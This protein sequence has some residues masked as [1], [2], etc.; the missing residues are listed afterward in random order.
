MTSKTF[1]L[2][3][4][5]SRG[6]DFPLVRELRQEVLSWIEKERHPSWEPHLRPN[7]HGYPEGQFYAGLARVDPEGSLGFEELLMA[8]R[9]SLT[10]TYEHDPCYVTLRV[11]RD[12]CGRLLWS[13]QQMLSE[14]PAAYRN[15]ASWLL[16]H[17]GYGQPNAI[18]SL[19]WDLVAERALSDYRIGWRYSAQPTWVPILKPH[20]SINWSKHLKERLLAD[21]L[22]WQQ[23]APNSP[24]CYIP[25]DPFFDPFSEGANQRLRHL[26]FPGDPEDEAGVDL[27]WAE[28]ENAIREREVVVFI[29]YSLPSYDF[30]A[31]DFFQRATAGK[32]IEV[33]V[34]SRETLEHYRR[35]LGAL[36][37]DEPASFQDS[38]YAKNYPLR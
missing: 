13:K 16:E 37:N 8:L 36:A 27:I 33:Y 31:T 25:R 32:R 7:L 6:T 2:G 5:F 22:D 17:H 23:I 26:I 34:P 38:P 35:L 28:A 29:G 9:N 19:N 14:L 4:G 20:G 12:A 30:F 24:F 18:I 21:S 10:A 11:L 15:F 1:V 3:A